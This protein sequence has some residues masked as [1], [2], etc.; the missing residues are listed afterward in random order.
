MPKPAVLYAQH[1]GDVRCKTHGTQQAWLLIGQKHQ[2]ENSLK[3]ATDTRGLYY[4][5]QSCT[6]SDQQHMLGVVDLLSQY[7][8]FCFDSLFVRPDGVSVQPDGV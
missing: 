1:A 5:K 6:H 3:R 4:T 2:T 7:Q 8:C